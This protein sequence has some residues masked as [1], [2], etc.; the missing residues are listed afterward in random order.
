VR[1]GVKAAPAKGALV[2]ALTA[3]TQCRTT[4]EEGEGNS[5]MYDE[6]DLSQC[7]LGQCAEFYTN[8]GRTS[9][10]TIRS[11]RE[12]FGDDYPAVNASVAL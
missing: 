11:E 1:E 7:L 2:Q 10:A 5:P 12:R 8:P 9:I 4:V 6:Y 3:S